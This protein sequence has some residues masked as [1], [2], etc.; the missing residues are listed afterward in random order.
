M[1]EVTVEIE[2]DHVKYPVTL[3]SLTYGAYNKI[4]KTATNVKLVGDSPTGSFDVWTM[5][6]LIT[7]ASIVSKLPKPLDELPAE[8]G[9]FLEK[10]A[11]EI[12]GL[13]IGDDGSFHAS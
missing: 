8:I 3:K 10:T 7:E 4:M 2:I 12:N 13:Q 1:T 5:R 6:R 11:M 9:L